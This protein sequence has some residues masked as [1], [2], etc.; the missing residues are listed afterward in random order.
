MGGAA[1]I[2]IGLVAFLDLSP[3]GYMKSH[4]NVKCYSKIAQSTNR[5]KFKVQCMHVK[6]FFIS[7]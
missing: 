5:C 1:R 3:L 2:K 6:G 4:D 7:K